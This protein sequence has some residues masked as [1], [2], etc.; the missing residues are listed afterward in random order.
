[1]LLKKK[2]SAGSRIIKI[3]IHKLNRWHPLNFLGRIMSSAW[4]LLS[5]LQSELA[6]CVVSISV[7]TRLKIYRSKVSTS[8]PCAVSTCI[9]HWLQYIFAAPNISTDTR[10]NANVIVTLL[11]R[12][13]STGYH[14]SRWH[15]VFGFTYWKDLKQVFDEK[16]HA[17]WEYIRENIFL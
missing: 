13:V 12:R 2:H 6:R 1:M 16:L 14:G 10:R 9:I 11:L 3:H 17:S 7:F 5:T 8:Y 15:P 4:F